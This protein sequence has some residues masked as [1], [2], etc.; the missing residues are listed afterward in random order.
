MQQ[1]ARN[2]SQQRINSLNIKLLKNIK[3][4]EINFSEKNLTV[5]IGLNGSG[6][7]SILHA[8]ACCYQPN[9]PDKTENYKFSQFF[10]PNTDALWA[11]SEL[12]LS[13]DYRNLKVAR[14]NMDTHYS[15]K[16]TRWSPRY[17]RRPSRHVVYI[18]IDSCVPKIEME[19]KNSFIKYITTTL[20]DQISDMIRLKASYVLGKKYCEYSMNIAGKSHYIGVK[21]EDNHYSA[22][23]MSA[24]EQRVF[25]I[26]SEVF[27]APKHAMIL[28]DEIDLLLHV[29]ALRKL[30]DVLEERA[31]SFN[32]QII[33]TSHAPYF[34]ENNKKFAIKYLYNTTEK[35]ICYDGTTT[36]MIY[37]MTGKMEKYLE[38]F[39]EDE[40]AKAIVTHICYSLNMTRYVS[41]LRY[42]A[43]AN[44]FTVAS[45]LFLS[46]KVTEKMLF[47]LDGDKN[48]TPEEI[49]NEI[50][51]VL[52]GSSEEAL[53]QR[54]F[55]KNLIVKFNLPEGMSPEEYI[56]NLLKHSNKVE[57]E[58]VI[59]AQEIGPQENKHNYIDEIIRCIGNNSDYSYMRILDVV[60]QSD[61]WNNFISPIKEWLLENKG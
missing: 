38:I 56:F 37:R 55:I 24:G 17:D 26:L 48:S 58:F 42:G 11:G 19:K 7:S 51:R 13:H 10:V 3:H 50:K 29:D 59:M 21:H 53:E 15:K 44:C 34:F 32:L 20:D 30:I 12:T 22:L 45:G 23:S 2:Y 5:I 18:G 57:D 8:L 4:L 39:V 52:T 31:Q 40:F 46:K 16:A 54:Q 33:F 43:A 27:N 61:E 14:T 28:I 60:S 25:K 47:V 49:D 35:T 41:I 6:K 36:D 9:N 1:H